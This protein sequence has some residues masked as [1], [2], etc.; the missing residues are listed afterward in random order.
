MP[1]AYSEYEKEYIR[2]QLKEEAADCLGKYGI[3]GTTVDKLVKRV[4]IPKG[5]FY[6]FYPSKELLIFE[7]LLEIHEQLDKE[8]LHQILK[9]DASNISLELMTDMIFNFYKMAHAS[10][11][12]KLLTSG[13]IEILERKLPAATISNHL[14]HDNF[15]IDK[16]LSVF[17]NSNGKDIE[18]FSS[19]FRSIF[20]SMI[21]SHE[22]SDANYDDGLK[23]LI[24]GLVIQLL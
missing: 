21:H 24:K 8:L 5:A 12:I 9:I 22:M 11:I 1:K 13:E 3:K 14:T 19:A 7:V 20:F 10:P 18:I 2:T 17:P 6:L 23:L 15:I 4:K 16:L